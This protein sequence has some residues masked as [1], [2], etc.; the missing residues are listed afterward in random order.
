MKKVLALV[1]AVIMVCTMAMAVDVS[2]AVPDTGST[3][4]V[5][6]AFNVVHPGDSIYFTRE[7][8][9]LADSND[10]YVDDDGNFV[11]AKN[12]V[13]ITFEKGAELV[14]SQGWV[15]ATIKGVT[16]YYYLVNTK[17]SETATLDN[18]ADII[19]KSIKVT[20]YGRS[21][22]ALN[23]KY[24]GTASDGKTGYSAQ[25][26]GEPVLANDKV[27]AGNYFS[28]DMLKANTSAIA[29]MCFDYGYTAATLK[30]AGKDDTTTYNTPNTI[31]TIE[32]SDAISGKYYSTVDWSLEANDTLKIVAARTL[33]AGE[34]LFFYEVEMPETG[35]TAMKTLDKNVIAKE[36][37]IIATLEGVVPNAAVKLTVEKAPEGAK[38]YVV[39]ADGS[40][41]DL[42]AK[43]DSNGILTATAVVTGPVIVTDG[44]LTA[45]GTTGTTTNPGT[46]ANDVV[47]VAAALAVVALVS[48]AAI[49]LKK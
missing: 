27:I 43:F 47:G 17:A 24:V 11:P 20:S 35:S 28:L 41:K 2:T 42:G 12:T 37:N 14:A 46:G 38:M 31:V 15:K 21:A 1:L 4:S 45:T 44:A 48:G 29:Y 8:L 33:K 36:V 10:P 7:E 34:K 22:A 32:K 13:A 18:I 40:V 49:S 5:E 23:L 19:I 3:S 16:D 30:V 9:N 26:K 6:N 39:N 25:T